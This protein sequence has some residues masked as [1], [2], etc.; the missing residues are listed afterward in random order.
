MPA[1]GDTVERL[2]RAVRD[3]LTAVESLRARLK[4][5]PQDQDA[6][7]TAR[8][9]SS[10]TETL[11]KL[12]R[13]KCAVPNT[14]S[15]DDDLPA[16]IDEFL[17]SL[18]DALKHSSQAGLVAEMLRDPQ[19][20]RGMQRFHGD[21]IALAHRH[22]EPPSRANN[23]DHW[24]TWLMLGGRGAG[25]TR[26]GAEWV[27]AM[28]H[29]ICPYA[30]RRSLQIAL[31]GETEHDVRE[32]MIEGPAGLLQI[33]PRRERPEWTASRRRLEWPNGGDFAFLAEDPEQLRGPQFDAAWCD[34]LANGVTSMPPSTCCNSACAWD[35]VRASSSPPRRGRS[36]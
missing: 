31:V 28:A 25:K 32:V 11:Q 17:V 5:E 27:R 34:E 15:Q 26:L 24:T 9:L 2:Y 7:R 4:S 13:L 30:D 21:F 16:D 8:T 1:I 22:Q 3:E 23:G 33:S 6:E 20:F 36:R 35:S 14:G 12:Q 29:G 10:L 18:R 19:I